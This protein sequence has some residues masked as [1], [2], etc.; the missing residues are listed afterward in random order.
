MKT[1]LLLL[2]LCGLFPP[3]LHAGPDLTEGCVRDTFTR[4]TTYRETV[5]NTPQGPV[6]RL[7]KIT[8]PAHHWSFQA[9]Y[10]MAF[11]DQTTFN[12]I[13]Q[14][15]YSRNVYF[16][17]GGGLNY[18]YYHLSHHGEKEKMQYAGLNLFG[19]LSPFPYLILQ[20]QPE[21]LARWGK[22]NGRKVS[23]RFVPVFL[24]GGGFSVPVGPGAVNLLFLFD[25]IQNKY[26]P[27]GQNLYY[28]LGY[29][30][31]F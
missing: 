22:Q 23:G 8:P 19:R 5:K 29:S 28:S 15:T 12:I 7:R 1:T 14:V 21:L 13:P 27:Y 17:L 9:S 24:A 10:G 11:G 25:I 2:L 20:V 30:I 16:S 4:T 3:L 31:H 18:I 6:I 26:T